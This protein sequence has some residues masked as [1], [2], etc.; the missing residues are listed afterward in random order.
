MCRCGMAGD[1]EL[2]SKIFSDVVRLARREV[3]RSLS[4]REEEYQEHWLGALTLHIGGGGAGGGAGAAAV[5]TAATVATRRYV[6]RRNM[7]AG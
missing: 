6:L 2:R 4:D 3:M 1:A 5:A 7:P